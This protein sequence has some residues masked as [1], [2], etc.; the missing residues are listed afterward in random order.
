MY[1]LKLSKEELKK[2]LKQNKKTQKQIAEIIG[3]HRTYI[4]QIVGLRG[5]SKL[6]AYAFCKA[7][8]S[9]FEIENLFKKI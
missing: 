9:D 8:S 1:K 4:S 7:I 5:V 6:C 2:I 3:V